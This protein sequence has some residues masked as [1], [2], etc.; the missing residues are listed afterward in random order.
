M[1]I[2]HIFFLVS[3]SRFSALRKFYGAA[4]KP[5]GYSEMFAPREDLVAFGSDYPYFWLKKLEEG[6]QP[7]PTHVAFDAASNDAV[8]QFWKVAQYVPPSSKPPCGWTLEAYLLC[9]RDEGGKDNGKPGIREE[10][11]RQPYYTAFIIDPDG[12]NIEAVCVDKGNVVPR[13]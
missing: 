12:N 6:Q 13:K 5:L 7:L 2:N 1:T 4:L 9:S 8:D 3:P 10:M 11:S